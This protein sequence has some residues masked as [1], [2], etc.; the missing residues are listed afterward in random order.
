[1]R[2]LSKKGLINKLNRKYLAANCLLI[3]AKLNDLTKKDITK[4]LEAITTKFRFDSKKEILSYE[5]SILVALEFNLIIQHEQDFI[6]HL[7]RIKS[8]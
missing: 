6:S 8:I 1:M 3:A 4:L 7:E 5:F 2:F